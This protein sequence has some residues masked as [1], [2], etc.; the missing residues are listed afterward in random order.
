MKRKI[1]ENLEKWKK[2]P[3]RCPLIIRGARQVG[4]SWSIKDFGDKNFDSV[5]VADFE[6]YPD[7]KNCFH[8]LELKFILERLEF[9]L[10]SSII[11]GKTL[12][13]FDEIQL[14]PKAL[15][16]LRYFKEEMPELHVISAGSLLEFVLN[17]EEFSFP[18]GRVE[19]LFMRPLSFIE[20]L[21]AIGEQKTIDFIN[22]LSLSHFID[23]N[24]HQYLLQLIRVYF[25]IG[26]MPEIVKTFADIRSD[27]Y[28]MQILDR[29]IEAL[30]QDFGKYAKNAN[31]EHLKRLFL[32]V[33]ELVGC[34]FKYSKIDPHASN[35]ARDYKVALRQ[36]EW[37]GLINQVYETNANGFPLQFEV[38]DKK[39]KVFMLDI[40]L[41]QRSLK[42]E[43]TNFNSKTLL[44][45]YQGALAEQFVGQELLA[46]SDSHINQKLYYW[47]NSNHKSAAEIDFLS[48]IDHRII[49]IEVKAGHTGRLKSLKQFM[50]QKGIVL[51]VKISE[52]TLKLEG[53]ILNVPFYLLSKLPELI[54]E[55]EFMLT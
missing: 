7:L 47:E 39:F 24:T 40:G 31:L 1:E 53:H 49:P 9:Y 45:F 6:K 48:S 26:G 11:P 21:N 30:K 32:K 44:D 38:N 3:V 17:E 19:F 13:F 15:T 4:K 14:C 55:A 16:A 23:I 36:L 33:P 18:V 12:L 51:G 28:C 41:L 35:P 54:Q 50:S 27:E 10:K 8:S 46:Y 20:F 2:S 29:L 42:A 25:W 34:H 37:A 22:T 43:K 52:D 5:V